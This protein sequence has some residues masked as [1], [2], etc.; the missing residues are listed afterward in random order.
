MNE[1]RDLILSPPYLIVSSRVFAL[2][3]GGG[4]VI[5]YRRIRIFLELQREI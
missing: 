4:E 2:D 5:S 1:I 3:G